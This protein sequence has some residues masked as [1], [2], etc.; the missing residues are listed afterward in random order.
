MALLEIGHFFKNGVGVTPDPKEAVRYFR[1]AAELGL[2]PAQTKLAWC[3]SNGYGGRRDEN[4]A[5]TWYKRASLQGDKFSAQMLQR[6][7][8]EGNAR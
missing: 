5:L 7:A 4:E 3:Y 8:A 2:L 1:A 6:S